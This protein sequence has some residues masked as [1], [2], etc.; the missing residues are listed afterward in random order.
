[1]GYAV[2]VS[3]VMATLRKPTAWLPVLALCMVATAVLAHRRPP[4][5]PAPVVEARDA[6]ARTRPRVSLAP[7][8]RDSREVLAQRHVELAKQDAQYRAWLLSRDPDTVYSVAAHVIKP[9]E[10]ME[11]R[12]IVRL[13]Q[14]KL[15][16][17]E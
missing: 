3:G 8:L 12:E 13:A 2:L 10:L 5:R 16:E 4:P 17:G 7:N 15:R 1:M 11:F 6:D 9:E 14:R